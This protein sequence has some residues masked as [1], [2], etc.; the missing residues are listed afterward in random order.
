MDF[1]LIYS[2][3]WPKMNEWAASR[4][5]NTFT[6]QQ[7]QILKL[8]IV[9]SSLLFLPAHTLISSALCGDFNPTHPFSSLLSCCRKFSQLPARV[10]SSAGGSRV[11]LGR[12]LNAQLQ[13]EFAERLANKGCCRPPQRLC[14]IHGKPEDKSVIQLSLWLA[15][16]S[17]ADWTERLTY[18]CCELRRLIWN[19]PIVSRPH[20]ADGN[21]T[22][23]TVRGFLSTPSLS[24][25][26]WRSC[27]V[28]V[29]RRWY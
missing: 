29:D 1:R 13:W 5:C 21:E 27:K 28:G 14:C 17:L 25:S 4:S 18:N 12:G 23:N 24:G 15:L 6:V 19:Y 22:P 11:W 20:S 26:F 3:L 10:S 9:V 7:N 2:G 16:W 8:S